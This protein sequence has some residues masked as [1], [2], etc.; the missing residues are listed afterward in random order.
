MFD[1]ERWRLLRD[2]EARDA[3][4]WA[5]ICDEYGRLGRRPYAERKIRYQVASE[6]M[7]REG[8]ADH[9]TVVDVGAGWTELDFCLRTEHEW[10]GRYVPVDGWLDG[11]GLD[12][13]SPA[14]SFEWFVALE[15][16]EHLHDPFR[17]LRE[18]M[19][20]ATAGVVVTTPNPFV[21]DL[22]LDPTHITP[23]T[24]EMLED[25]G[26]TTSLH[27]LYGDPDDGIAGV[28]RSDHHEGPIG[29]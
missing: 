4:S 17:L 24:Q 13:W 12:S 8:L 1:V 27:N 5:R 11:T 21:H 9:H 16:L 6:W 29:C 15:I 26:L 19:K 22:S 18:L 20:S 3:E 7:R 10:R 28:W 25:F 2:D 14:R 23:I